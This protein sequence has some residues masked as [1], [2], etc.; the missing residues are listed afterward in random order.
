MAIFAEVVVNIPSVRGAFHYAIPEKLKDSLCLG[1]YV[2]VPFGNHIVQGVVVS[3][4]DSSPVTENKFIN[5]LIDP[6]P[7]VNSIQIDLAE[8]LSRDT[9]NSL[10][11]IISL[12]LPTGLAN[13]SDIL[14]SINSQI[15]V[16]NISESQRRFLNLLRKRG[17]LRGRQIDRS[18]P[19]RDWR[20]SI[21]SLVRKGIISTQSILP[22][23]RV[24]PKFIRVAQLAVT[25]EIAWAEMNNLGKTTNTLSRRQKALQFLIKVPEAINVSWVYAESGCNLGDLQVLAERE[26]IVLFETEIWRD[27][28][29][30]IEP[31]LESPPILTDDQ[32]E[33]WKQ[34]L[35][36]FDK[37]SSGEPTRPF[38]LHGVTGSG[39]TEIYLKAVEHA[40]QEGK[41]SIV[42]VPEISLTPQTVRR[43]LARFPGQVGLVHSRLSLGEQFDTWRRARAGKIKIII[44]PRSALFTPLPD[45][46]VIVMDEFHDQSYYQQESPCYDAVQASMVYAS[47]NHAVSIFG[48]ATPPVA[49]V[50]NA[51]PTSNGR[52]GKLIQRKNQYQLLNLPER[53]TPLDNGEV[54]KG[55]SLPHVEVVDMREEL[56]AGNRGIFS[57]SLDS[58][59]QTT[60]EKGE[61]VIL[62]LNRRGSASYVFCRDC[63]RSMSCPRCS[64]PLTYHNRTPGV[65]LLCHHCGYTRKLPRQCPS[66]SSVNIKKYGL[67]IEQ[68]ESEVQERYPKARTLRWDSDSTQ[69]KDAHDIIM[70]HF[71]SQRSNVLVGTQMLAKG[72]D[73]PMVTLVGIILADVGLNLPDPFVVEKTFQVLTQV[74]GRAGRSEKGGGVILQTFQPEHYAIQAASKHDFNAFYQMEISERKNLGNPPFN[75]LVR[76]EYKN[77]DNKKAESST[78]SMVEYLQSR[79]RSQGKIETEVLGP[80]PC[81]Y[82]KINNQYRWQAIIRGP[83]PAALLP[84]RFLEGWK[85]EIDPPN[86]L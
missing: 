75:R 72:L 52:G 80:L 2:T 16:Q 6:E 19:N 1:H 64:T 69:T 55:T 50:Y 17:Q 42:M 9:H 74:S 26:L 24:R 65:E 44:G 63:G 13:Q 77:L 30:H 85:V 4:S 60:L 78:Q 45:I 25:P 14:Y 62:F 66:C 12:F 33:V 32:M 83:D 29:S 57:V 49:A 3:F 34:I 67:G 58:A 71:I 53:L 73:L 28:V 31:V 54:K 84:S 76:L 7:I 47:L 51:S 48:S 36:G 82:R 37:V 8:N 27:P 22:P 15:N 23:P 61:Q 79:K 20:R 70:S 43:F 11:S 5:N 59:L 46:G 10:A 68:V 35:S 86:L 41:S 21:Q 81:F 18:L 39:K 40:M 56:K 38:L